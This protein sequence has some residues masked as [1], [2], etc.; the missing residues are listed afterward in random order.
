MTLHPAVEILQKLIRCATV[1]PDAG[2]ALDVLETI[3]QNAGFFTSRLVFSAPGT[4]DVDN[5][6][7][8]ALERASRISCSPVMS[9]WCL[10]AMQPNG[11]TSHLRA[12][13]PM[14]RSGDAAART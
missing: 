3:L 12:I 7:A 8:R 9:M 10:R 6:Y 4:P 1:T 13:L 2:P 14:A 11:A 5:L